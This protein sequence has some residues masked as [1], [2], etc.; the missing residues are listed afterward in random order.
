MASQA[1][2]FDWAAVMRTMIV[3]GTDKSAPMGPSTKPQKII[4]RT[5]TEGDRSV[6]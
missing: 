2:S 4:E 5:T 3:S 6:A 1:H